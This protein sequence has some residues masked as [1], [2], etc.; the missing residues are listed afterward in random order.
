[1]KDTSY[2]S[3]IFSKLKVSRSQKQ[4]IANHKPILL[5]SVIDLMTQGIIGENQI[6]VS[7][8]LISTFDRYW[9]A[10][11]TKTRRGGLHYPFFHLQNERFWHIVFRPDYDNLR[12]TTINKLKQS[13]E[14]AFLDEEL[15]NLL[16]DED[17]RKELVDSLVLTWFSDDA[18]KVEEI[19]TINRKLEESSGQENFAANENYDAQSKQIIK[20]ATVRNAFFRK[21]VLH[22]YEYR[23]AFCGLK[24]IKPSKYNIVDGAHIKPFAQF[25]DSRVKNGISLCKNHHWAF[26]NGFFTV[27]EQYKILISKDFEDE[28]PNAKPMRSYHGTVLYL[29][30][31]Q[32]YYPEAEALEWHRQ[33]VFE[34]KS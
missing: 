8:E 9:E 18:S 30:R 16:Q 13:V 15:F 12:T 1:M 26:D 6:P 31:L 20:M 28:S 27:D 7:D 21:A 25:F 10:I 34:K 29:P 17:S 23:C 33:E 14:Y 3:D 4:G 5:L 22:T 11:G 2:Y 32:E 19:I 24:I